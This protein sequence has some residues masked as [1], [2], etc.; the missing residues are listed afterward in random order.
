MLTKV[1]YRLE[2]VNFRFPSSID[3]SLEVLFLVLVGVV[4][5]YIRVLISGGYLS[6]KGVKLV[7]ADSLSFIL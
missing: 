7:K 2:L 3:E 1:F 6:F 5:D 4:V